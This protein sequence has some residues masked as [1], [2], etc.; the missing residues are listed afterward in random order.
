MGVII[1]FV[2]WILGRTERR[3]ERDAYL[4]AL[5]EVAA[6]SKANADALK[7]YFDMVK[8]SYVTAANAAKGWTVT[9]QSQAVDEFL[10][11]RSDLRTRLPKEIENDPHAIEAWLTQ[12][13][14][15]I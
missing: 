9:D 3:A 1:E 7:G 14:E 13:I 4:K 15:H 2:D 6:A 12:E 11:S 5:G 10:N 8:E